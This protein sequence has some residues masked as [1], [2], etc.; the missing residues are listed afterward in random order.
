MEEGYIRRL[1]RML[2]ATQL[3]EGPVAAQEYTA[4]PE[5][6]GNKIEVENEGQLSRLCINFGSL[7]PP[8]RTM[9][10]RLLLL[11][12][13]AAYLRL[14]EVPNDLRH[15]EVAWNHGAAIINGECMQDRQAT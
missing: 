7:V 3:N 1:D 14:W 8:C 12:I 11:V 13:Y 5:Q 6:K 2:L 4:T 10:S 15:S 9:S